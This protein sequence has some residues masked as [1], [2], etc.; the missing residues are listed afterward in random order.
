[1]A[2]AQGEI[3]LAEIGLAERKPPELFRSADEVKAATLTGYSHLLRRVWSSFDDLIGVLS[4][5][6]RPTVYVQYLASSGRISAGEQRRFWNNGMAP[7]LVRIT[8]Q[9]VQIYSSLRSPALDGEDVDAN[10]RLVEVFLRATQALELQN[11]MRSVEAGTVYDR[12]REHFDPEQGIDRRLVENLRVARERMGGGIN[13]PD[14]PSIHRL[15]GR[16]LFACYLE[17]REA[18]S[19][20]DFGG[21]GAGAKAKFR[22]ILNLPDPG[23]TRTG[24]TRLFQRLGRYF[25]GNLFDN[26]SGD[27]E[28]MRDEDLITLGRLIRGDDL[29]TGQMVLPFYVY[30]FSVIPI[31]TISAV[32]EDFIREEDAEAQR[33]KGAYYTPPKLVE[34]TMNLAA[35][36]E[37]DLATAQVLDPGCGSGVFLVSMFNRLAESWVRRHEHASNGTRARAMGKILREQICG[38]DISPIACQATCF[39]LYMAMLDFLKPREIRRLGRDRLPRLLLEGNE[40]PRPDG[41]QTVICGDFLSSL[42]ALASRH[43]DLVI[44]NPPWVAR[45]N[46]DKSVFAKWRKTHSA[47]NYPIPANQVACAFLWE[48]P[49]YLK[50]EGRACLLLPAGLLLG[51]QTD[52]FQAKW[53][54]QHRVEKLAQLTD[55]RF[56]LFPGADHPT[57][58]VRFSS[59]APSKDDRFEYLTPKAAYAS[60]RDNIVEV[61]SDDRKALP[62]T[63]LLRSADHGEAATF[64]L[65]YNW[66]SPRDREFLC[67]LRGLPALSDLAGEP[68]EKKRWLK[69]QGFQP[70]G[71]KPV[72]WEPEQPFLEGDRRFGLILRLRDTVPIDESI[73]GL[74]RAPDERLFKPPLV[75]LN[76]GFSKFAYS[77]FG[78]VFQHA[79]RSIAG[80]E[81]DRELLMFLAA[82][83]ASPLAA[84]LG[85]S[86]KRGDGFLEG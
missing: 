20:K 12:Y 40:K 66:A 13:A 30:D 62:L 52:S 75:I 63:E 77:S 56:F 17:A 31:E 73:T 58:A 67:R 3:L 69:G 72:F 51:N 34:F 10:Q 49:Q 80:P 60:L 83:L 2:R 39:S 43:F 37:Q 18:L 68:G 36:S 54:R 16:V 9:E 14:L 23:R 24:L 79:L 85:P 19:D 59:A 5:R 57:I 33:K 38:V 42:P 81:R 47:A 84:Y 7:L 25:R 44:G 82:T 21:L 8:P 45:G 71:P 15:L 6:G 32:Y 74:R 76:Q 78:V 48:V 26:A 61:E 55:L 35:A 50:S 86:P 70:G 1:M 11:F 29:G 22:E 28:K 53:F 41:P 46:V 27:L 65:G 64:W 4:I